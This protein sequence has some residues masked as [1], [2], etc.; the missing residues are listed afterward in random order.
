MNNGATRFAPR[1]GVDRILLS[2]MRKN[3]KGRT[4]DDPTTP[5]AAFARRLSE[6]GG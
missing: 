3:L 6:G 2:Q 5:L 1:R 4:F